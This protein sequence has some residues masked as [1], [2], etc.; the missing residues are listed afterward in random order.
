MFLYDAVLE[1]VICG[2]TEIPT[3]KY[4]LVLQ[5]FKETDPKT[6]QTGFESQFNL[7]YQVTP[8]PNDVFCATAKNHQNKNRSDKYLPCKDTVNIKLLNYYK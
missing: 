7:L 8:N 4:H 5:K 2:N 6:N 1:A 3:N